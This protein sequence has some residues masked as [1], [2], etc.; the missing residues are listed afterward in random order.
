[1]DAK[2]QKN[3]IDLENITKIS[4]FK[5]LTPKP[6]SKD[7]SIAASIGYMIEI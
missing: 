4:E 5:E 2:L 1:M 6:S 7:A 3:A